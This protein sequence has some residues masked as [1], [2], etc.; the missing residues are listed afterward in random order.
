MPDETSPRC[1]WSAAEIAATPEV[2]LSHP[3]NERSDIY[4]RSLSRATGMTRVSLSI[5]R[6][7]PAR[8]SF[9]YHSHERDEEF[10]YI[11][12]GRGRAEIEGSFI[13]VGPGDF[14]GFPTPS[15]AHHLTNPYREDLVYLMGG[16]SSGFDIG[17]FPRIG[18]KMIF[19][20]GRIFLLEEEHLKPMSMA[21][22]LPEGLP[23]SGRPK[24]S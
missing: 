1:Y 12:S 24:R 8:E 23:D 18:R 19:D 13:E 3:L 11:L 4:L 16:E 17:N 15:V 2:H 9:I 6:V 7:P 10:L 20:H 14:M 22:Y 21:D 5:A